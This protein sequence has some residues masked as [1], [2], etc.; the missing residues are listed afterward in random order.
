MFTFCQHVIDVYEYV[1]TI[2]KIN[3]K[4]TNLLGFFFALIFFIGH[5]QFHINLFGLFLGGG[6]IINFAF[7]S[8]HLQEND[9]CFSVYCYFTNA[10]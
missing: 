9:D 7:L 1:K 3:L 10:P 5:Y 6:V 8:W 4:Y 2:P